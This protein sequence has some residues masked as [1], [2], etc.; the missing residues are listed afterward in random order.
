MSYR[1]IALFLSLIMQS[2]IS[3]AQPYV[4]NEKVEKVFSEGFT[5]INRNFIITPSSDPKFWGIYGD[6][7]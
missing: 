2:F 4:V 7:Y 5:D 6:G 3:L 1:Y